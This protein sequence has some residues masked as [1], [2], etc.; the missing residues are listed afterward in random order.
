[1]GNETIFFGYVTFLRENVDAIV[2]ILKK[3]PNDYLWICFNPSRIV[4]NGPTEEH[5]NMSFSIILDTDDPG[6]IVADIEAAVRQLPFLSCTLVVEALSTRE[7][8]VHNWEL[9]KPSPT[10]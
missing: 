7:Y 9:L 10:V 3:R 4:Q 8:I 6:D 5:P 2:D 1:M